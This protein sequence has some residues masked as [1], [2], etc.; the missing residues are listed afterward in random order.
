[1]KSTSLEN[2]AFFNQLPLAK[3]LEGLALAGSSSKL[4]M[5]LVVNGKL[6]C[7]F[8]D[9]PAFSQA[10]KSDNSPS[11]FYD[12]GLAILIDDSSSSSQLYGV[13]QI[14]MCEDLEDKWYGSI[15]MRKISSPSNKWSEMWA[16]TSLEIIE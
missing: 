16:V 6:K 3:Q 11:K 15:F 5:K 12:A 8:V 1:M 7:F 2:A 14:Q 13:L 10:Y 4:T 9:N